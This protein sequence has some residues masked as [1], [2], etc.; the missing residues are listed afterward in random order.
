MSNQI[1]CQS[2][3]GILKKNI[4]KKG[5]DDEDETREGK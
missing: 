3:N 1:F 4:Q 5:E 2:R